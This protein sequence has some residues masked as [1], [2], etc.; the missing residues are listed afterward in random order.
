M[1]DLSKY[2]LILLMLFLPFSDGWGQAPTVGVQVI[3]AGAE[4]GYVMVAPLNYSEV[5]LIDNCG[6][7]VNTWSNSTYKPGASVYLLDDGSLLKTC[8]V[9]NVEFTLGGLGGRLERWS[10]NDSLMWEYEFS[11]STYTQH[12]DIEVLPHCLSR[13]VEFP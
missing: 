12:H 8:R 5:Y 3:D 7:V 2:G 4:D 10:W 11:T 6:R 13:S 9:E 1:Q